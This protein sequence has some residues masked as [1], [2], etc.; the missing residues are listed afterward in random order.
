MELP[1]ISLEVGETFVDYAL[2]KNV[3][4]ANKAGVFEDIGIDSEEED[5]HIS[6]LQ[7]RMTA[8][9]EKETYVVVKTLVETHMK[10]VAKT[11]IYMEGEKKNEDSKDV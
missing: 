7:R 9:D 5:R 6:E 2:C 3:K 1:A 10:T 4:Q 8:L 11:L